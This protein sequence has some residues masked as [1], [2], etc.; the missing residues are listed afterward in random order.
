MRNS[1]LLFICCLLFLTCIAQETPVWSKEKANDWYKKQGWLVG[2]NFLPSTAI[3]QLEMWQVE[4]YDPVT[5]DR[6]LGWAANIGMNVMRV[7]LH[8]LAWR[9]DATGFLKRMDE[10]LSIASKHRIKILFTIFDDCWN[11]DATIGKQPIPKPGIHNSGWVEARIKRSMMTRH[12]G[13]TWKNI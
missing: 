10:F 3:N 9:A 1:F 13:D 4:T 6:E 2:A 7:Y 11:P 12:S 5:I 8:D